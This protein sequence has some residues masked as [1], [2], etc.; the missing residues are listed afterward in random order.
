MRY[1]WEEHIARGKVADLDMW[2]TR[3]GYDDRLIAHRTHGIMG[4]I[5]LPGTTITVGVDV[6]VAKINGNRL[7]TSSIAAL[8]MEKE[9]VGVLTL[10]KLKEPT[11]GLLQPIN[12][13][14]AMVCLLFIIYYLL[15]YGILLYLIFI[16]AIIL[17]IISVFIIIITYL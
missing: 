3:K 8:P 12:I 7:I 16:S 9:A 2:M 4:N 15:S 10:K 13:L 14:K 5:T 1:A 6:A 17:F 11:E